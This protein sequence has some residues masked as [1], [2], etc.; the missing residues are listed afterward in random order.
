MA[1]F[2]LLARL[3]AKPDQAD[4]V[5]Q[6]L[7]AAVEL[8]RREMGTVEWFALKFGPTSFGIFDTFEDEAGREMHLNGQIAAALKENAELWLSQPFVIEKIELLAEK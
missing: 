5:E 3:E 6:T 8:A 7:K 1:H 2:A 4:N